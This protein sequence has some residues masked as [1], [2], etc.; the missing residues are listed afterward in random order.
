M[1]V[2]L[3]RDPVSPEPRRTADDVDIGAIELNVSPLTAKEFRP[4]VV[5]GV[6][7]ISVPCDLATGDY[8]L[9]TR[10]NDSPPSSPATPVKMHVTSDVA[11]PVISCPANV[12][13]E[14][15]SSRGVSRDAAEL[16]AFFATVTAQDACGSTITN[17][18][19]PEFHVGST[20]VTFTA[21]DSHGNSTRCSA[22]VKVVDTTQPT[23]AVKLEPL[24][25]PKPDHE[26]RTIAVAD[27]VA[28]VS[29]VCDGSV[30]LS[31]L[32]VVS[33]ASDEAED[34]PGGGDGAT[35]DDAVVV[36]PN[37]VRVRAER[38][39]PGNGRVYTIT[40]TASDL[41]GNRT[42]VDCHVYVPHDQSGD[43]AIEGPGPGYTVNAACGIVGFQGERAAS[44]PGAQGMTVASNQRRGIS[45]RF[46]NEKP[47]R[48]RLDVY[49]VAGNLVRTLDGS[50][51]PGPNI[52]SW[53]GVSNNGRRVANGV[54]VFRLS[55]EGSVHTAKSVL[56]RS[57]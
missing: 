10:I 30:G 8:Y 12:V 28:S 40:Y 9:G 17:D 6:P 33:V 31:S 36:C 49:D 53:D 46:A 4:L 47:A 37:S 23:I 18:A 5:S 54:Y 48:A 42:T 57:E 3:S 19:P 15:N 35:M 2:F 21:T 7:G 16:S 25:L 41:S 34:A 29:D 43:L 32:R 44:G 26:Y 1:H 56:M 11:P 14:C 27:L 39:G 38:Q 51:G 52:I 24:L 55:V 22:T 45:I 13:V 50:Y 20:T